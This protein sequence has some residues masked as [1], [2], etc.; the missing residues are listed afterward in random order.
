M[1]LAG[2]NVSTTDEDRST[3][4]SGIN[5]LYTAHRGAMDDAEARGL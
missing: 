3:V 4:L 1:A 5:D 2:S